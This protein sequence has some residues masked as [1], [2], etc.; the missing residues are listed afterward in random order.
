L[1]RSSALL[2]QSG[3]IRGMYKA[4]WPTGVEPTRLVRLPLG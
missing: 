1:D 3:T 4:E 2:D